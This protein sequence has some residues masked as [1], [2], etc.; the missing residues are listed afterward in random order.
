[1]EPKGHGD[2]QRGASSP[3]KGATDHDNDAPRGDREAEGDNLDS[4]TFLHHR[5]AQGDDHHD[6][7]GADAEQWSLRARLSLAHQHRVDHVLGG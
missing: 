6:H 5:F 4:S 3:A 1:M 2:I 7:R